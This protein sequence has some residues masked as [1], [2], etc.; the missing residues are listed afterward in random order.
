MTPERHGGVWL[1]RMFAGELR[2]GRYCRAIV[3]ASRKVLVPKRA[4]DVA[5]LAMG[6]ERVGNV[7]LGRK[8]VAE[9]A[10]GYAYVAF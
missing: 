1:C 10:Q 3:A 9:L 8:H 6:G 2:S 7:A 5:A 4:C